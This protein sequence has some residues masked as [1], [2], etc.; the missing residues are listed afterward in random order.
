MHDSVMPYAKFLTP[1]CHE[2]WPSEEMLPQVGDIP[3]LFMSG[4]KDEIV[5]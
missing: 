5:P 4:L 1:L 2:I 3:I